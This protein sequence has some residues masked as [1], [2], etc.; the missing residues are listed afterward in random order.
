MF[1]MHSLKLNLNKGWVHSP[2]QY[3]HFLYSKLIRG[4][5]MSFARF[6]WKEDPASTPFKNPNSLKKPGNDLLS[7]S[8]PRAVPSAP[9]SLTSVFGMG[10]GVASP[11]WLPGII[12]IDNLNEPFW[13]FPGILRK[14]PAVRDNSLRRVRCLLP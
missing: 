2:V 4:E 13:S 10:T 5:K 11:L 6:F 8:A 7:H 14:I 12:P 3:T 9:K 1:T